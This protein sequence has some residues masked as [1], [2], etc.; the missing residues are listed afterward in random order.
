MGVMEKLWTYLK[1]YKKESILAPLFKL[2][3]ACMDLMVPLIVAHMI[4]SGIATKNMSVI[5]SNVGLLILLALLGIGFSVT[6]QWFAAKA[7]VGFTTRLRRA[8]FCH[9]QSFS[10][11]NL[12]EINSDTLIT[13]LTSDM[14]QVQN[15]LNLTLRL[16][17]RS[18]FIV[19]GS[20]LLAFTIDVKSALVF[21][22]AI[23]LLSLVIFYIMFRSVPLYRKV[24]EKLDDLLSHTRENLLGVR[25]I[26]AFRTEEE[27]VS[28]FDQTNQALTQHNLIVGKLSALMNPLTYVLINI[29]TMFLIYIGA[30]QV[31][32]GVLAQGNVVALY[33]YMLQIVVELVKMATLM[34]TLNRSIA[35]IVRIN[36]VLET[37]PTMRQGTD[38]VSS[39]DV[40]F[41][42]VSFQYHG[43]SESSLSHISFEAPYGSVTGIIGATGSGK[44][45]LVSLLAH[46]Y[47]VSSGTILLGQKDISNLDVMSVV[48]V[49]PQ[50][51]VLFEGTV[52]D[53]LLW[54]KKDASDEELWAAIEMAQASEVVS[55][56][57]QYVEQGGRNLSGGQRQRL[58]IARALVKKPSILILDDSASALDYLT[59]SRLRKALTS[60]SC[61]LFIVSQR[62]TSL[63]FADQILVLDD[64]QLVGKGTHKDLLD[65]CVVYQE[66]CESQE[67]DYA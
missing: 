53:N 20:M 13:R 8:V 9:I 52:R 51:A 64:G 59:E 58:C 26:R 60:L 39:L 57:D 30:I 34:V 29:A 35:C 43:A 65:T 41:D 22:V 66:I 1:P 10:Y 45:T 17:L 24:Q 31:N 62:A 19:L 54:G 6:A 14:N 38:D 50:K 61:S 49:V 46:F 67:V 63:L 12:D 7:S 3:E 16:L 56:L 18:P 21:V 32:V 28:R 5:L 33:N 47:E 25:V 48:G 37:Q 15:G 4:N 36:D 55:S 11:Q 2:L 27:Q 40:T 44:S 42:D 23:P